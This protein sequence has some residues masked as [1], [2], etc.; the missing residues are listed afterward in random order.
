MSAQFF[1]DMA[2]SHAQ[3]GL[4]SQLGLRR[5][6]MSGFSNPTVLEAGLW[7]RVTPPALA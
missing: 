7:S 5:P 4:T 3:D 6:A 2:S 1:S